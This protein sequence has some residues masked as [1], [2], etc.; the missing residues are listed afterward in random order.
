MCVALKFI[1]TYIFLD[2][3]K[4]TAC[5]QTLAAINYLHGCSKQQGWVHLQGSV[6]AFHAG[7]V[8]SHS[9]TVQET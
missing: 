3:Q 6:S 4:E 7:C 2:R 1:H 9:Q 5:G 8:L